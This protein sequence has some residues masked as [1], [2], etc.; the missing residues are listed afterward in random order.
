MESLDIALAMMAAVGISG[1]L[2]RILPAGIPLPLIQIALGF[3]IA[4]VFEEG[5]NLDPD[6]FFLLFLPPLLFLDGWRIPKEGLWRE[7]GGI[8]QLS[9]G[10]VLL[11]VLGLG[12]ILHWLIPA[13]P[14]AVAFAVA[15]IVSPTDPVAVSAITRKVPVPKRLMAVLEGESLFN[16]ATGLVAFRTAVAAM[17]TGSFSLSSAA[18]SFIW[19]AAAGLATGVVVTWSLSHARTAVVK[20]V[21]DEPGAEVLLSLMMPFAA[22]F[23]A[24]YIG[25]S[26][27]L[28]AVSAGVTMSYV[29]LRGAS[30]ALTR[31][32]R[33]STWNVVQFALNGTMFVLLGE[34]LP[35]IYTGAVKAIAETGHHNPLWLLVYALVICIVLGVFRFCWVYV[36]VRL[37]GWRKRRRGIPFPNVG[38]GMIMVLTLGGVRGAITLAG[39]LTL[40]LVL[41]DGQ[42]PFPARDL[43]ILLAATVIITSLVLASV[44]MPLVVKKLRYQSSGIHREQQEYLAIQAAREA[45]ER[46]LQEEV[47]RLAVE[48]PESHEQGLISSVA[49]RLLADIRT[50]SAVSELGLPDEWLAHEKRVEQQ[51]RLAVIGAARQ[52]IFA[53]ARQHKI[54]DELAR[55][56]VARLDMEEVRKSH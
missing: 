12:F 47:E 28:A 37:E 27:I 5:V 56:M 33:H 2:A 17:V 31:M 53:L 26:G 30:S 34:Q 8:I 23:V 40:P 14:L 43:A 38:K 41:D 20:R 45:A 44:L 7:K 42:T 39:V 10:L 19:V 6:V 18:L 13:M 48:L 50:V 54:S 11:T 52:S 46:A 25:A 15:A 1:T 9:F 24:E 32:H 36:S 51:L 22:Y 35:G 21:G 49:E 16:D 4:G 3:V 55:E 29:E